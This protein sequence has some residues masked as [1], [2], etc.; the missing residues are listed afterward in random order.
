MQS[1]GDE[2]LRRWR[3]R[4]RSDPVLGWRASREQSWWLFVAAAVLTVT[5]VVL[6][7]WTGPSWA[8]L[9]LAA[10]SAVGGLLLTRL[11]AA[12]KRDDRDCCMDW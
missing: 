12:A 11:Q 3:V 1:T 7:R 2:Y 9:A 10:V 4:R 8:L 6:A 5:A